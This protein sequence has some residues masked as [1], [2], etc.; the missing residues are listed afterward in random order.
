[1]GI[2]KSLK[3][4]QKLYK[5]FSKKRTYDSE[6]TNKNYKNLF[7][8][9]KSSSKKLYYKNQLLKYENNLKGTW[10]VIKEFIRKKRV[11]S[12]FFNKLIVDNKEITDASIM[13]EK[14]NY[15]DDI[16]PN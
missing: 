2:K 14:C 13:V 11:I 12:R 4:K 16:G 9:I 8:K 10:R 5:K 3:Q 7:E 6:R 1:M 15:F